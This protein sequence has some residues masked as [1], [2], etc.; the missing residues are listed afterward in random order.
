M[1][2]KPNLTRA[3]HDSDC[4]RKRPT[5]VTSSDDFPSRATR[6]P[7]RV[8]VQTEVNCVKTG[9]Q[10][11]YYK[12]QEL[13]DAMKATN[14][15]TRHQNGDRCLVINK[16]EFK[17]LTEVIEIVIAVLPMLTRLLRYV[18]THKLGG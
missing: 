15:R 6:S 9:I 7:T 11:A 12:S 17:L 2:H 1:K 10:R 13:S 3:P 14:A 8:Q 16:D 5:K 18:I 4:Q